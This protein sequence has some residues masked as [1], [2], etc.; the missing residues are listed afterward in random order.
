MIRFY[1]IKASGL[2]ERFQQIM[3][4]SSKR[5]VIRLNANKY[6]ELVRT[7]PRNYSVIVMFTAMSPKR[8]CAICKY[9]Y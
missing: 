2:N 3:D 9:I 1:C 5:T 6:R 4:L 7:S 8:Q